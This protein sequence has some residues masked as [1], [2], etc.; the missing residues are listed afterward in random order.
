MTEMSI[1]NPNWVVP[2]PLRLSLL[3]VLIL[4]HGGNG[5]CGMVWLQYENNQPH[6]LSFTMNNCSDAQETGKINGGY[7]LDKFVTFR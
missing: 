5:L 6:K 2:S 3:L 1:R 4:S 7:K